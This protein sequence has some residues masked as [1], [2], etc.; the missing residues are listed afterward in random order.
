[1]PTM[2]TR[3]VAAL[4]YLLLVNYLDRVAMGFAGPAIMKSLSMSPADFGLILSSFGLGYLLAQIPGGVMADRWGSRIILIIGPVMWA[5][6]TGATAF[7]TTLVGFVTV[8][9]LFGL[10][11][12]L[13]I[14][15]IFKTVGDSFDSAERPRALA[16]CL[17]AGA[18][19]P[20]IAGP[21]VGSLLSAFNWQMVFFALAAPAL[22]ASLL[23]YWALPQRERKAPPRPTK[24]YFLRMLSEPSFWLMGAAYLGYNIAFWGY[25]GWMPSYL[26]QAH[27]INLKSMGVLGGIPYAFGLVGLLLAGW[28]GG[29]L[30]RRYHSQ[31][32]VVSLVCA[33]IAE[34]LAYRAESLPYTL[35]GLCGAAFFLYGCWGSLGA[36]IIELAPPAQRA[37]Y[38]GGISAAGQIGGLVAPGIVGFL[39]NASGSFASGFGFMI[40]ALGS[41]A[42]CM[43]LLGRSRSRGLEVTNILAEHQ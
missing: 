19:G 4:W 7:A 16:I 1:M 15:A 22:L 14:A 10:S 39:V 27:H 3:V 12:G 35:A 21:L 6:F 37:T 33:G 31:M 41:A 36:F 42:A 11:E 23:A 18:L 8:R 9:I 43:L 40:A 26:A 32:I 38:A 30:L 28:L 20:L 5:L 34:L 25:L 2:K 29:G 24:R 13:L 17:S